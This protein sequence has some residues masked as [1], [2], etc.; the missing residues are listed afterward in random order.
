MLSGEK[1]SPARNRGQ[2]RIRLPVHN[3]HEP[4]VHG[5]NDL[6]VLLPRDLRPRLELHKVVFTAPSVV[7]VDVHTANGQM[8]VKV[9]LA[10][11][12]VEPD[13]WCPNDVHA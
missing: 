8:Q 3:V 9:I 7:P 1:P 6:P 4:Q 10:E 13:D 11:S 2:T 12:G 5:P